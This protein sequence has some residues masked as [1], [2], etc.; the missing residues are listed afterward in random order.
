[1]AN[2]ARQLG[3]QLPVRP[4]RNDRLFGGAGNDT[5]DGGDGGDQ[6]W[7][8]GDDLYIVDHDFEAIEQ[9]HRDDSAVLAAA[10]RVHQQRVDTVR[11]R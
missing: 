10:R 8:S 9:D 4:R 3:R 6:L 2:P 7:A 1:L 5:L 11:R